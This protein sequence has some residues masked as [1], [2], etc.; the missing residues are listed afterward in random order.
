MADE[1]VLQTQ[2]WLNKTYGGV[3]GFDVVPEDGKTGII[4]T[5]CMC[6]M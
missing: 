3:A 5:Q 1:M 4:V 2:Q 6:K